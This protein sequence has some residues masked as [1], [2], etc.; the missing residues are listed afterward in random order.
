MKNILVTIILPASG[1]EKKVVSEGQACQLP[2]QTRQKNRVARL[3]GIAGR[4]V[5]LLLAAAA[6]AVLAQQTATPSMSVCQ[7][8]RTIVTELQQVNT[9]HGSM[10]QSPPSS[11]VFNAVELAFQAEP[12]YDK[13]DF[14]PGIYKVNLKTLGEVTSYGKLIRINGKY[15][16]KEKSLRE[17]LSN[18]SILAFLEWQKPNYSSDNEASQAFVNALNTLRLYARTYDPAHDLAPPCFADKDEQARIWAEFQQKAAAWRALPAKPTISD[19]VKQHR[20]LAEDAYQQKQF[21]TA[22]AEYE[23][24]LEIDPL[25]AQGHFNAAVI[26]GELKDYDDAVWHIRCYLELMPDAP[27]AQQARDQMLLWQGKLKQQ[28]ATQ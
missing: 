12:N 6:P 15:P 5:V 4:I 9:R 25:W 13:K 26:Y 16:R 1:P 8:R 28:A 2:F 17:N 14:P 11:I 27:D 3:S 23:A 22:A 19:D 24:G 18:S 20:L 10:L 21:D 7:A